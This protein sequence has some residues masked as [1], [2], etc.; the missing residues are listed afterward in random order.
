MGSRCLGAAFDGRTRGENRQM[1]LMGLMGIGPI[2]LI[3]PISP[4]RL[5][6][7]TASDAEPALLP[8]QGHLERCL[9]CE[10]DSVGTVLNISCLFRGSQPSIGRLPPSASQARQR[11]ISWRGTCRYPGLRGWD[12]VSKPPR[13]VISGTRPDE[14]SSSRPFYHPTIDRPRI[15]VGMLPLS[16]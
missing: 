12:I 7:A 16:S 11:S 2:S 3:C 14:R 9:A 13:R 8:L 1:G 5:T 15:V 4:H 6:A 10:A